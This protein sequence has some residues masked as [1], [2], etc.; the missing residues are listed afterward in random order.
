MLKARAAPADPSE[1]VSIERSLRVAHVALRALRAGRP[2]VDRMQARF[3]A[4]ALRRAKRGGNGITISKRPERAN[5][6]MSAESGSGSTLRPET[7]MPRVWDAQTEL[8]SSMPNGD[9]LPTPLPD[10][11]PPGLNEKRTWIGAIWDMPMSLSWYAGDDPGQ[12]GFEAEVYPESESELWSDDWSDGIPEDATWSSNFPEA[13]RDDL[14]SDRLP[15]TGGI[16]AFAVGTGD[17][18]ALALNTYYWAQWQTN[19]GETDTGTAVVRGSAVRRASAEEVQ[20]W[21]YCYGIGGWDDQSCLFTEDSDYVSDYLDTAPASYPIGAPDG[22]SWEQYPNPCLENADYLTDSA[23]YRGVKVSDTR[24]SSTTILDS[25]PI[26]VSR[27]R[28]TW[29]V[30]RCTPPDYEVPRRWPEEPWCQRDVYR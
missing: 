28:T 23:R 21:G 26:C 7:Y 12:R 2:V 19:R 17:G 13:Y 29:V 30:P 4:R 24:P 25:L 16:P 6:T 3:P 20:N 9:P 8:V 14:A 5:Q 18:S 1:R 10:P 22:G 27:D 11:G 15:V